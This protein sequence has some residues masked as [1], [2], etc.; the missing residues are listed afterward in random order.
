MSN[1]SARAEGLA[2]GS[3]IALGFSIPISAATDEILTALIVLSWLAAGRF[4]QTARAIRDNPVAAIGCVWLLVH[5]LGALYS[6]GESHDVLR[7]VSK[8]ATFVLV[9]IAVTMLLSARDR[10]WALRALMGAIGLTAVLST[11]RWLGAI[12]DDVPLLKSTSFSASVVFKYHL[13]QNLLV[14]F[15]A[16]LFAVRAWRARTT[17][18]RC[19]WAA[20][21]I[22]AALNVL[23]MGDGRIGQI[24]LVVLVAYFTFGLRNARAITITGVLVAIVAAAAYV[25]PDSTLHKRSDQAVAEGLEW[26]SGVRP[27]KPSSVGDRLDYYRTSAYIVAQ[28]PFLGVGTGGFPAAYEREVSGTAL[29]PTRNPH[30][31]FLLRA[32][33]LGVVG[34][35]LLLALFLI[36]WQQASRLATSS[37]ALIVRGLVIA[38]VITSLASSPL[39]DHT[40]TMLFVWLVGVL[41]AGYRPAPRDLADPLRRRGPSRRRAPA[42]PSA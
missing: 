34:V 12:P 37:D 39:T 21:S 29:E 36:V 33:E 25:A 3:F 27:G 41:F 11:L 35:V 16:F 30:N 17:G 15:G 9:P 20:A 24:V 42:S 23:V 10:E 6:I 14:A 32:V 22:F 2:R 40:E 38:F 1:V 19:A 7:V 26:K 28:H 31:E 4:R 8:A 13:T 18:M 5:A